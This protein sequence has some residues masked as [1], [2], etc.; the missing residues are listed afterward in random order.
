[1][2]ARTNAKTSEVYRKRVK[3]RKL[4]EFGAQGEAGNGGDTTKR[5]TEV[6]ETKAE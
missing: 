2:M 6:L 3:R 1:M 4:A 5:A